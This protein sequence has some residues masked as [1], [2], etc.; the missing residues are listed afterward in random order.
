MIIK[1]IR[2]S[3]QAR[4]QL[5]RLKTRTGITQWNI[6]CRWAF[7]LSLEQTSPPTPIEIDANSNVE[8]DWQ[9]FGGDAQE[10]YLALL[11]E[12]CVL[13]GMG[14][15][16]DLLA[17]QFRLHLHR[18]IGYLATPHTINSI[19]DLVRL[20]IPDSTTNPSS[21]EPDFVEEE[22]GPYSHLNPQEHSHADREG[23]GAGVGPDSDRNGRDEVPRLS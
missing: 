20:A 6:L 10:L 3:G 22:D 9:T 16:D 12:R 4:E 18:G 15:S 5:I 21:S 1:Q 8:M 14:T 23:A 17:R 13:D 7:C 19:S 2:L 11:K